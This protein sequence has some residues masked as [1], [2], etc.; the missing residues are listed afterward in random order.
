[1]LGLESKLPPFLRRFYEMN[2]GRTES[3]H[4]LRAKLSSLREAKALVTEEERNTY[5]T[6]LSALANA[7]QNRL[8]EE[9]CA[10][11]ELCEED[12]PPQA[13]KDKAECIGLFQEAIKLCE[14]SKTINPLFH[15]GLHNRLGAVYNDFQF[16]P[17]PLC[18]QHHEA[19]LAVLESPSSDT[20]VKLKL[21]KS[22]E[23]IRSLIW[24]AS[25]HL[26]LANW[27]T[28]RRYVVTSQCW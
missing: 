24:I 27:L 18:L 12:L 4:G 1:M 22:H 10:G 3:V 6:V 2:Q 14:R 7:I 19:A 15:W 23:R 9:F 20:G 28:A 26:R 17:N 16:D 5:A 13:I 21:M 11:G 8:L 25:Y